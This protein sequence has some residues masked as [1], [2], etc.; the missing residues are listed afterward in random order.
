MDPVLYLYQEQ[1]N[2]FAVDAIDYDD[3]SGDG[4]NSRIEREIQADT[5]YYLEIEEIGGISG[6]FN[7]AIRRLIE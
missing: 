5:T 3:D 6:N 7:V 4:F 1:T 2:G